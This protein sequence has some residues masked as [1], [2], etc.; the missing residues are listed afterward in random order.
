MKKIIIFTF[1]LSSSLIFS[2]VALGKSSISSPSVSL[3]FGNVAGDANKQLGIILPW[4]NSANAVANVVPGTLIFDT[5]DKKVK[6]YKE[7]D[8]SPIWF[9]LTVDNTGE[10]DTSLQKTITEQT[11]AKVSIGTPTAVPGILVLEDADK[12]MVLP[13]VDKYSSVINPSP[14]MMVYDVSNDMICL[15]NG[16]VWSFWKG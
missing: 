5:T 12:A 11:E 4:V 16:N 13:L 2:Q 9:D 8:T 15:Y 1:L 6:Y 7:T 3:E 14:G 10:V